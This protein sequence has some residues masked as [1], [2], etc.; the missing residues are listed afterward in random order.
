MRF[1]WVLFVLAG[2]GV[3]VGCTDHLVAVVVAMAPCNDRQAQE[4]RQC[5]D[6]VWNGRTVRALPG[7]EV[8]WQHR[9]GR[10]GA[11]YLRHMLYLL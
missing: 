4:G 8:I 1:A 2:S 3:G 11:V 9:G 10:E 7:L 6:G 5:C